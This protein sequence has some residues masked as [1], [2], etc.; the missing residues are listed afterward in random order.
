MGRN[1]DF[2]HSARMVTTTS[3]FHVKHAGPVAGIYAFLKG[4][5]KAL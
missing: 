4:L 5:V 1:E 2:A 3:S